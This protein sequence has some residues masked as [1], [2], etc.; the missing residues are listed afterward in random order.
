MLYL[1][2]DANIESIKT[3]TQ[4]F[5][6]TGVTT[7]PSIIAANGENVYKKIKEIRDVIGPDCELHAQVL[8]NTC[9]EIVKEAI[10]LR[11]AVGGNF[12]VKVPVTGE[13]L[14]SI[15]VLKELGFGV[16]ATAIF[17]AQQALLAS[18]AGADYVA[19]YVNRIDNFSLDGIG[20]VGDIVELFD[21]YGKDT[22]VLAASF[23]NT[24]Q[25]HNVAMVGSHAATISCDLFEKLI[26]HPLTTAAIMEF[27]EK[28]SEFYTYDK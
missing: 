19:P 15:S 2:D 23:K 20:V 6:I 24:Q 8:A 7:N 21:M 25:V 26:Y 5:P 1:I 13:G 16:T 14:K 18:T 28:G 4:Y 12:F 17:T 22:K 10:R 9:D 27:E 11:D 3:I